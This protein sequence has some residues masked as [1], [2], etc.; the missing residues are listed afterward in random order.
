MTA[1]FR[2]WDEFLN[3]DI[4]PYGNYFHNVTG[5]NDYDNYMNTDAPI[6]FSYFAEYVNRPDVRKALHVG[7]ATFNSGTPGRRV[8]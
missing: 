2:V 7:N 1:A 4:W 3:G 6:S 8:C 5:L